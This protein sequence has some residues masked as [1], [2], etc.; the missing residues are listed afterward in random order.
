MVYLISFLCCGGQVADLL[1]F[2]GLERFA[3][4]LARQEVCTV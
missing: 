2:L 3:G 1:Q 4:E